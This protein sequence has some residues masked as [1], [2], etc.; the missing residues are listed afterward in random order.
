MKYLL[1]IIY[2]MAQTVSADVNVVDHGAISGGVNHDVYFNDAIEE[3]SLKGESVYIP[4]GW[5]VLTK[6]TAEASG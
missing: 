3:A 6:S 4:A 2:F 5:W 1:L